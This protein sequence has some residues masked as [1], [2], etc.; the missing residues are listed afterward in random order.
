MWVY[1]WYSEN[2]GW[3]PSV[4]DELT[5]DQAYWFPILKDAQGKAGDQLSDE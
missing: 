5:L 2:K 4:V 1:H 3:P